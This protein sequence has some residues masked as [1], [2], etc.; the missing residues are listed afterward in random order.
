M[1]SNLSL[2]MLMA[3]NAARGCV[4]KNQNS[5]RQD[6]ENHPCFGCC[7]KR[8]RSDVQS[9]LTDLIYKDC[10]A[11]LH[12]TTAR[13]WG[14]VYLVKGN[15]Y[16]ALLQ[17][18]IAVTIT[19]KKAVAAAKESV[20]EEDAAA[21]AT[22]DGLV[23]DGL[24]IEVPPRLSRE[25]CKA[26]YKELLAS[27]RMLQSIFNERASILT[28]EVIEEI[29]HTVPLTEAE[30]MTIDKMTPNSVK[31]LSGPILSFIQGWL[32]EKK[33]VVTKP[34]LS[35][36]LLRRQQQQKMIPKNARGSRLALANQELMKKEEEDLEAL[37]NAAEKMEKEALIDEDLLAAADEVEKSMSQSGVSQSGVSQSGVSQ[38]SV[39]QSTL[40]QSTLNQST[41][42][43]STLNQSTLN[44][45]TLN[46]STLTPPDS[47][48]VSLSSFSSSPSSGSSSRYFRQDAPART[49]SPVTPTKQAIRMLGR[50]VVKQP[51]AEDY[52]VVDLTT[53]SPPPL[54]ASQSASCEFV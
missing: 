7:K 44:Q 13:G 52:P 48:R 18:Q 8:P 35:R 45:S 29:A 28:P 33:I 20:K 37:W 15:N 12:R 10:L 34:F 25:Q 36:G 30:L 42:N 9:I 14:V 38:S 3:T 19:K 11:E 22:N 41:L 40:N 17:R 50:K 46:Q 5:I 32:K 26:L 31:V 39:S 6:V 21:R 16:N 53:N 47:K 54:S 23:D 49:S 43:Q 27:R 24:G 4:P 51:G 2:T 1:E